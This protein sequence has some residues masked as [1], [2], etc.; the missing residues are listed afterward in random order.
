[1]SSGKHAAEPHVVT[2]P[3]AQ[4][5]EYPTRARAESV[6]SQVQGATVAPAAPK[7]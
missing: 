7:K 5:V 6:A 3:G 2:A 4:P 1:M